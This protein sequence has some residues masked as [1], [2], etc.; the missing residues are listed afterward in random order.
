MLNCAMKRHPLRSANPRFTAS[1]LIPLLVAMAGCS[2]QPPYAA[3]AISAPTA[4]SAIQQKDPSEATA[5][6][7]WWRQL[8]DPT[9]DALTG[10]ALADNPTLAQAMAHVDE[11]RAQLGVSS[12]Q[13]LPTLSVNAGST[14]SRSLN[15]DSSDASTRTTTAT[16]VGIG[17]SWEL[18]LFGRIRNSVEASERKLD[19]RDADAR[20]AH[21]SLTSQIASQVLALRAC[22]FSSMVLAEDIDSREK[23]LQLTRRRVTTGFVAPI[24]EARAISGLA[25]ARTSL[26]ARRQE[27]ARSANA[28]VALSGQP[29]DTVRAL[30]FVP[31]SA[32]LPAA[33]GR[34]TQFGIDSV[35]PVA[36]RARLSLPA[37]VL[38]A[39]PS[40]VSAER[41]VAAAWAEIGVARA[42]R[43]PRLDLSA[44]L[45]GQWLHAAG[46]TLDY[47]A[48][49]AGPALVGSLFDG[50]RG[51]ASVAATEARYR[52]AVAAL[53][54]AVRSAAQE[55]E[56]ALAAVASSDERRL[57]THE[58]V[59]AAR[60]V[61]E[62]TEARWRAGA[63]SLF[64]LED[65][66]R[67]FAA[68]QDSAITAAQDSGQAWISLVRASG[69]AAVTE[70]AL[71]S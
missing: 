47:T 38:A 33:I 63:V 30:V 59:V 57:T 55:T 37:E 23:T 2:T 48:W 4:W 17:P 15:T 43:L 66:R 22:E 44:A 16:S 68:A 69:N 39:H 10:A 12:A 5:N 50:G 64:E 13:R 32:S 46:T 11:A 21:L 49:L 67:Q 9:I 1:L 34:D 45:S 19:A 65:A 56:D 36:P 3:N 29:L 62:A 70:T 61:L 24:E 51:A 20:A 60:L 52:G 41:E 8:H 7:Q 53:R 27:C 25:T 71:F 42:E 58:A 14:R 26:A 35:M 28:L 6:V 40:V 54:I 18:D 31:L